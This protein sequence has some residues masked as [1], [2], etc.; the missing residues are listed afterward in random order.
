MEILAIIALFALLVVYIRK[1]NQ[2]LEKI[3]KLESEL[4]GLRN[5]VHSL[6]PAQPSA[7]QPQL[8]SPAPTTPPSVIQP[9]QPTLSLPTPPSR[10]RSEWEALIGG[11]L[12]NRIGAFAL[13]L[14]VGFFLK[15]AFDND[16]ISETMR[17]IIGF[18]AGALLL[19]G[20]WRFHKKNLAI[21]AQGLIG[22]G[23]A[24]LYLSVYA[25]FNFYHLVSQPVAL[26]L[27]SAVTA[28]TFLQAL[29]YDALAVSLLGW[30]GGF[31][32]PILLSTGQ[33]NEAGLFTYIALL[34]LGL[35]AILFK[36][37]SWFILE[38]LTLAATYLIYVVWF[39]EYYN[40]TA[41][42]LTVF[43]LTV[44]WGLFYGLDVL[45]IFRGVTAFQK[46]RQAVA[47]CNAL[48]YYL[49]LYILIDSSHHQWMSAVTILLGGVYFFTF[50]LLQKRRPEAALLLARYTLTAIILLVIATAIQ[51]SGFIIVTFW[52]LEALILVWCG[53]HWKMR[54]VRHAAF[55]LIGLALLKLIFTE[56]AFGYFALEN[57][58]LIFNRRALAFAALAA[59]SGFSAILFQRVDEKSSGSFKMILHGIWAVL[60]FILLTVEIDNYFRRQMLT[61]TAETA[62]SLR[63][64]CFMTWAAM[65]TL[66]SLPL[67]WWGMRQK[68]LPIIWSGLGSLGL[69]AITIAIQ[70][71]T[72]APIAKFTFG[73]NWR[74]AAFVLVIAGAVI[75]ARWLN[76][77]RRS[78]PWLVEVFGILQVAIVLLLLDLFTSETKDIF[79][80]AVFLIQQNAGEAS[81]ANEITRLQNLQ[82]LTLSGVWLFYSAMLMIAGIWRRLQG[83]RIMAIVLFGITILKIFIYDLSFLERLYRIFSFIGLGAI[84]LLVSYL[85]QR[86]KAVIFESK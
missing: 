82:Q 74:A 54:Y 86:Y 60:L 37:D 2:L 16:L 12:L 66:Y 4:Y 39:D 47:G 3:Q 45:R 70:G 73:L 23:I 55:G 26:M 41:L 67:V 50:L 71:L 29:K 48:F 78:F 80:K 17:V 21:F 33:S 72:F 9:P 22:A 53:I 63:F 68:I 64:N 65:W 20:G 62:A 76:Q 69:A 58:K 7:A 75:H 11:K 51:F 49:A 32:T 42:P 13:I 15:Y 40:E 56:G 14:G 30:A 35:L 1:T 18:V 79:K 31:L 43:F 36:K 44:F 83:L 61:A 28:L 10:T 57:F 27:M 19:L 25:S 77:N 34:D 59:V 81:E 46:I 38:P 85:Y 52:A 84:L 5:A 6:K 8:V 24:I